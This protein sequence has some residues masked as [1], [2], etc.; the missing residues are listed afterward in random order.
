MVPLLERAL[1]R[2]RSG[3]GQK[4][5]PPGVP[6]RG[7]PFHKQLTFSRN[8]SQFPTNP[9]GSVVAWLTELGAI[10][11]RSMCRNFR[12]RN[13]LQWPEGKQHEVVESHRCDRPDT[14]VWFLN[15]VSNSLTRVSNRPRVKI[16][17][18][19]PHSWCW[20]WS[21]SC[22]CSSRTACRR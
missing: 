14:E 9:Y 20:P 13:P 8:P 17:F 6:P 1:A 15:R 19:E 21:R 5:R 12:K 10:R 18:E 2:S 16:W 3:G 7:L 22:S 11:S 4:V